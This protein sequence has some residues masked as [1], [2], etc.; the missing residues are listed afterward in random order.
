MKKAIATLILAIICGIYTMW[1]D[2]QAGAFW[3]GALIMGTLCQ[4]NQIRQF[5]DKVSWW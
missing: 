3:T 5:T 4:L 1:A 2:D